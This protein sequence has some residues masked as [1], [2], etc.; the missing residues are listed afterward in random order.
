M[1]FSFFCSSV[2]LRPQNKMSE[3]KTKKKKGKIFSPPDVFHSRWAAGTIQKQSKLVT[4]FVFCMYRKGINYYARKNGSN[5]FSTSHWIENDWTSLKSLLIDLAEQ[6]MPGQKTARNHLHLMNKVQNLCS[7]VLHALN[8]I[9][10]IW[11]PSFHLFTCWS[12]E[13]RAFLTGV[14]KI[15]FRSTRTIENNSWAPMKNQ[16]GGDKCDRCVWSWGWIIVM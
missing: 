6:F 5:R 13:G 7:W 10:K 9:N 3:K 16:T 4:R 14:K 15:V 12:Q 11:C 1:Q 8:K 2:V